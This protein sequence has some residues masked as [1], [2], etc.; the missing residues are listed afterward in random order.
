[1]A[2]PAEAVRATEI[3]I[4]SSTP[5]SESPTWRDNSKVLNSRAL[6]ALALGV[7]IVAGMVTLQLLVGTQPR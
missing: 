3:D 6:F 5:S 4:M 2:I 1:V 7:V